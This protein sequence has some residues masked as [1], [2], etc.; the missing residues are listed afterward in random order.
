MR[1]KGQELALLS[2]LC[3]QVQWSMHSNQHSHSFV[4]RCHSLSVTLLF[5]NDRT[6]FLPLAENISSAI[7]KGWALIESDRIIEQ[8]TRR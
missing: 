8:K 3:F 2:S 4:T 5:V 1:I 6:T 7:K